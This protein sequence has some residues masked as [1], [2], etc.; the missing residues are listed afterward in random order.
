MEQNSTIMI[1]YATHQDLYKIA[2]CHIAAFPKSVTSLLGEKVVASMFQWYL[3]APN[4]FL[5]YVEE[6]GNVT[7]YCGGFVRNIQDPYGSSSGMTQFGFNHAWRAFALRPWLLIHPEV[8]NK[9]KFILT[10]IFRKLRLKRD[11]PMVVTQPKLAEEP[12]TAGLVIIG[13]IPELQQKGIGTLLQHEFERKALELGA[14]RLSLTVKKNNGKAVKS[15][16]RNG[17]V[18]Y[19]EEATSFYMVK[20]L[21]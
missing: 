16:Y 11:V 9:Y 1:T 7:G 15:Y 21:V 6:N 17:Y 8:R 12:L 20:D 14:K 3:S 13:V 10:N 2:K 19:K 4:N 5:F 18:T